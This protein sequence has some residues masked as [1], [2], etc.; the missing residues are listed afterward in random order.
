VP[1]HKQESCRELARDPLGLAVSERHA[2]TCLSLP[3]HPG[4]TDE[5]I[6]SVVRAVNDYRAS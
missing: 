1:I 5:M 3:C 4:I 2:A 6:D